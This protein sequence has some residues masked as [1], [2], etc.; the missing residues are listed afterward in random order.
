MLDS[1]KDILTKEIDLNEILDKEIET[2]H[3]KE[4]L[5]QEIEIKRL[6]ELLATEI[7]LKEFLIQE[8]D[9][10]TMFST[11]EKEEQEKAAMEGESQQAAKVEIDNTPNV[12]KPVQKKRAVPVKL[13]PYDF[14]LLESL[15]KEQEEI[16]FVHSEIMKFAKAKQ[17]SSVM[18]RLEYLSSMLKGH[19]QRSDKEL[20]SYLRTFIQ[21]RYPKREK[22]FTELSLEMKNISIEVF[23]SLAQSP[24]IPVNDNSVDGFIKE[25][26]RVGTLLDRRIHREET[27]LFVMYEESNEAVS[28]S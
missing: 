6:K 27:V 16:L 20:Y 22:A 15:S 12:D 24:N 1:V 5:A 28:I 18:G 19:F 23:F 17:Y 8:I 10:K 21:Q 4:F 25:F 11:S 3:V 7:K 9:I 14:A 13:P 2:K 26:D